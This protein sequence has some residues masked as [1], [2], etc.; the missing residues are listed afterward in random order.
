[1]IIFVPPVCINWTISVLPFFLIYL[2]T[3]ARRILSEADLTGDPGAERERKDD[4]ENSLFRR[5]VIT[6]LTLAR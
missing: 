2:D 4:Q 3:L 6:Y 5:K 1:M